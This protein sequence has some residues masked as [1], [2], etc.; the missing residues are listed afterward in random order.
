[1]AGLPVEFYN[2]RK[3][4]KNKVE[5]MPM[6]GQGFSRMLK[7]VTPEVHSINTTQNLSLNNSNLAIKEE[8]P[9]STK[10]S[11]HQSENLLMLNNST[12]STTGHKLPD[13]SIK[14]PFKKSPQ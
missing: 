6:V 4:P 12:S 3:L 11:R 1:M 10:H 9:S 5:K 2:W 13:I 7:T 8:A 14:S